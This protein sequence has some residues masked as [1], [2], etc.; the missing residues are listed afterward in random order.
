MFCAH[1]L[2]R[3]GYTVGV[4]EREAVGAGA[5]HG[6]C[7]LIV[8]SAVVP[9]C[10]PGA[11]SNA[12]TTLGKPQSALM[13]RPARDLHRYRWLLAFARHC[14]ARHVMR[15]AAVRHAILERS[16]TLYDTFFGSCLLACD[17]GHEGALHVVKDQQRLSEIEPHRAL[18]EHYGVETQVFKRGPLREMAPGLADDVSAAWYHP[19]DRHV[20]PDKLLNELTRLAEKVGVCIV[21][22]SPVTGVETGGRDGVH[23]EAGGKRFR[24]RHVVL[25][26]GAWSRQIGRMFGC[27]LPIEPGKGYSLTFEGCRPPVDRPCF[28]VEAGVVYTPFENGFRIGGL[29]DFA[30]MN[31]RLTPAA[32]IKLRRAMTAYLGP[33]PSRLEPEPWAGLRPMVYDEMPII[34]RAPGHDRVWIAAGHGKLGISMG[35]AT[36]KAIAD[37]IAG[38]S[39]R[40]KISDARPTRF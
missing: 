2:N 31:E 12:L 26:A 15:A 21:E 37:M 32:L 34:G 18:L 28:F 16:A 14:N 10:A 3:E 27:N 25:A 5:S 7:G 11:V 33:L 35:P 4:L 9:L 13:I 8:P 29:L 30:G 19:Q 40:L 39:P 1:F 23:L 22:K 6:N 38:R 20:R 17:H 36:G 24:A